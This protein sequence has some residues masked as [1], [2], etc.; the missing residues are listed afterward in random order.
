MKFQQQADPTIKY[1]TME[2]KTRVASVTQSSGSAMHEAAHGVPQTT[3]GSALHEG[4]TAQAN[5]FNALSAHSDPVG[6][7]GSNFSSVIPKE[8]IRAV[9]D[10]LL[11]VGKK[12]AATAAK[13]GLVGGKLA[14]GGS[15]SLLLKTRVLGDALSSLGGMTGKMSAAIKASKPMMLLGAINGT[16]AAGIAGHAAQAVS[17]FFIIAS[18]AIG[19]LVATALMAAKNLS[20][21]GIVMVVATFLS[22]FLGSLGIEI[23]Q[24]ERKVGRSVAANV[25]PEYA[26]YVN[27]A[28]S[29]CPEI[30]APLIAA[31]IEAES[32]WNPDAKSPVG[33]Q[34][35]SQ[36]MP[37]T[38]ATEGGDYNGDGR[39]DPLDPADAI[40]SQGHFMCSIVEALR[41][42]VT[43]GAITISIQEAAL[44]AY[45]AGPAAVM[46]SGGIPSYAETQN[47]VT[48][49]LALMVKYQAAQEVPAVGGSLGD[50]LEWAKSIAMDDTNHYVLGSQG[51]T[52]WD[53][54]G[55]TGAFMAR[56][57]V[58]LPRTA[59][60]QST[61]PGG[62]DVPYD[63]MQPGDL[64]F[65][66]WGDGSWHTAIALGGGQMVSADSPES[67]INIEPV[68]PG[69]RN[70]RRF[71]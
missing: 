29:M 16:K 28:G 4:G 17:H 50:A 70:V 30:T 10:N 5:G 60:E 43:I 45:N 41:P 33:A 13:G 63:Q 6:A 38:W 32:G 62:V 2:L 27:Q 46:N 36:F 49:I 59:R 34:G 35:I 58:A 8:S 44:A 26:Q 14:S 22:S 31:Q 61:A 71:L 57:G 20:L 39:A 12:G 23:A 15:K 11:V 25:P 67:G 54:S 68:F 37:G 56:L 21:L 55:L 24:Q 48:K 1:A 64:I 9:G 51:P 53:C 40:P 47:Y 42:Y 19:S 66:A 3:G 52:A 69:V 7:V 18:K 65:W